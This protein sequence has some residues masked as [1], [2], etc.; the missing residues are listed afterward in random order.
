MSIQVSTRLVLAGTVAALL[1]V[2]LAIAAI[3]SERDSSSQILAACSQT[4][5][6]T[7]SSIVCTPDT[8]GTISGAP[9]EMDITAK[10][11]QRSRGYVVIGG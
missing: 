5:S 1:A 6:G 11:A 3:G 7:S 9:S 4:R 2:L 10:N 8:A